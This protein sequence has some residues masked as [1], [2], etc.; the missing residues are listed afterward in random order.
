MTATLRVLH[1]INQ[2]TDRAGAEVSLREN[3]LGSA[4]AVEHA[5]VV[6]RGDG[7]GVADL[8][9]AG[10]RIFLPSVTQP[11]RLG[12]MAHVQ[13]AIRAF[14]PDIVHTSL[15]DADVAGRLAAWLCG[16]PCI[17]SFVNTPY[18]PEARAA[19]TT[20]ARKLQAVQTLDRLLSRHATSA[21]HA[22]SEATADHAVRYLGIE[23]QR[24]RVVPRGRQAATFGER[25]PDRRNSLREELDWQQRPIVINVA[26]QEPQKGHLFLLEAFAEVLRAHPD[27]WLVL[28]GRSGRSTAAIED[29]IRALGLQHAVQRLGVRSDVADLLC[30]AD[31]FAFTSLYEGLGGA[32]VEA[33]GAALPLASF[34]IAA[35]REVV[36][37]DYP[38]LVPAQ[39]AIRLA[40]A[41]DEILSDEDRAHTVGTALR[42]RFLERYELASVTEQMSQLYQDLHS[43]LARQ[44][45]SRLRRVPALRAWPS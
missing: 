23:R 30:A 24:I 2:L 3:I 5:V 44:P 25:S 35:I 11:G 36:G 18:G 21:F 9:S 16:V 14:R 39:D 19:E 12:A 26:R 13:R 15:F 1:V 29:K 33:A 22:I 43:T 27:A 20:P 10:V 38:W 37:D 17:T 32:A 28:V 6:L 45:T 42:A 40:G 41:I 34:D 31:V 8:T 7:H 4:S